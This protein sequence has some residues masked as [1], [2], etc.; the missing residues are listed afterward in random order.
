MDG[1]KQYT[2][3]ERFELLS[4]Y[5]DDEVSLEERKLVESWI[6]TDP[7]IQRQYRLLL[8]LGRS[9]QSLPLNTSSQSVEDT[10]DAVLKRVDRRPS[11]RK[12]AG[13]SAAIAG[14][15]GALGALLLGDLT[16]QIAIQ[17][18]GNTPSGSEV[19]L[20]PNLPFTAPASNSE[21]LPVETESL[22]LALEAPPVEIL[23]LEDADF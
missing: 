1:L 5:M 10:L 12:V 9:F 19:S 18:G 4:A 23:P 13:V 7:G 20:Q 8:S 21:I 22:M 17:D 14:A 15:A 16:P 3:T 2:P 6:D 11:L